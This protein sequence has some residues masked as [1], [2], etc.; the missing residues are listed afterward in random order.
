MKVKFLGITWNFAVPVI[1]LYCFVGCCIIAWPFFMGSL[2]WQ[3]NLIV[4]VL[5]VAYVSTGGSVAERLTK[6]IE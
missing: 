2:S 1:M 3:I 5:A 4:G 6:E